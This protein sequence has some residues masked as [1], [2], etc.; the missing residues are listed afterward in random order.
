MVHAWRM[1]LM[2]LTRA[3]AAALAAADAAAD[4][5]SA[6]AAAAATAGA[7]ASPA[8][9]AAAAAADPL[10]PI[11]PPPHTAPSHVPAHHHHHH[12]HHGAGCAAPGGPASGGAS[13]LAFASALSRLRPGAVTGL[14]AGHRSA[15]AS[16]RPPQLEA[17]KRGEM[18][19]LVATAVAEEGL[20]VRECALVSESPLYYT[21]LL[22]RFP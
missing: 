7:N 15:A 14:A 12:H 20:D 11:L 6:A 5:A 8:A 4:A 3:A 13:L 2:E 16:R 22:F 21:V 18:N 1:L 17:F 19:V 9:A 10:L